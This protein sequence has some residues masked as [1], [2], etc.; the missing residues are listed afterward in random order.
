MPPF[1]VGQPYRLR[2]ADA[3]GEN[4]REV[5]VEVPK[6]KGTRARPPIVEPK[7]LSQA[8]VSPNVGLIRIVY[9]SGIMGLRFAKELDAAITDLRQR[10]MSRLIIDLQTGKG[11]H[12]DIPPGT[13][14]IPF[15][16]GTGLH[17][18]FQ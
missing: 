13:S 16:S 11:N 1:D 4:A 14:C 6:R 2:I 15:H 9:F 17:R 8:M 7:S 12:S 18:S 10:G 3:R 5:V